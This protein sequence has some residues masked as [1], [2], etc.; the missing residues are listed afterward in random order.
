VTDINA[1]GAESVAVGIRA[2]GGRAEALRLD[3]TLVDDVRRVVDHVRAQYGRIDYF[4]NNAGIAMACE[5]RDMTYER[6]Q[7]IVDIN[8]WGVI[9]GVQEAYQVMI[10]QGSGHIVNVASMAGIVGNVT[11]PAYT[12]TKFAVVGLSNVLRIEAAPLGVNVSLVCPAS[13]DTGIRDTT[14]FFNVDREAYLKVLE[15]SRK[16]QW[17]AKMWDVETA[18]RY[19]VDEVAKN[20]FMI[21]LPPA[22]KKIWCIARI[23]PSYVYKIQGKLLDRFRRFRIADKVRPADVL[24]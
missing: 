20:A 19:I 10:E 8:L 23:F 12:T 5:T 13:V 17:F 16:T 2:R 1:E 15:E 18:A 4:Y 6:W 3:V 7:R 24:G 11:A 22:A 9:Y 21:L 14:P